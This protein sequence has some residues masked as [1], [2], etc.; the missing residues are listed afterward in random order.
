MVKYKY[1][2][3]NSSYNF[4]IR[5]KKNWHHSYIP[6]NSNVFTTTKKDKKKAASTQAYL[7]NYFTRKYT[8][9]Q[10]KN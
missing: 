5:D 3:Q 6:N 1:A 8:V 10:K 9:K 2:N 4:Y 7:P